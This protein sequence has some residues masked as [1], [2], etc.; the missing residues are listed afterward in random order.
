MYRDLEAGFRVI[1]EKT[2]QF[3]EILPG[4][5]QEGLQTFVQNLDETA[6]NLVGGIS[7]PTVEAAGNIAKRIPSILISTIV[8]II[9]AYFLLQIGRRYHLGKAYLSFSY[10]KAHD[11][12]Y[13]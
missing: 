10:C 8:T 6:G 5:V 13:G 7:Q 11:N 3:F 12:G 1:G 4:G 9:S 2:S